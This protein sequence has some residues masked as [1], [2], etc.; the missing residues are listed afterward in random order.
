[1][2]SKVGEVVVAVVFVFSLRGLVD[3][4]SVA[5]LC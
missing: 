5:E 1:M 3:L 2:M 4:F